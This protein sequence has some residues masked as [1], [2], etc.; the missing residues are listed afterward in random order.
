MVENQIAFAFC[1][2]KQKTRL[3][4]LLVWPSGLTL[5]EQPPQPPP[6]QLYRKWL[7]RDPLGQPKPLPQCA[8][9]CYCSPILHASWSFVWTPGAWFCVQMHCFCWCLH[10]QDRFQNYSDS[11]E[12]VRAQLVVRCV[13]SQCL[14]LIQPSPPGLKKPLR[15]GLQLLL[16]VFLCPFSV[17]E[18]VM[19]G[20]RDLK[21][22]ISHQILSSLRQ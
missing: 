9:C 2:E 18:V 11:M 4:W 15:F 22:H 10:R 13:F 1:F 8:P 21:P 17:L 5:L 16:Y 3:N 12:D 7:S 19:L 20:G 14:P 6:Q